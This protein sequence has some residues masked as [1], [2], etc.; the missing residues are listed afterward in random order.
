M[1]QPTFASLKHAAIAA[2]GSPAQRGSILVIS[3]LILLV[4]TIIGVTALND[5]VLEEK[6]S[7][8]FQTGFTAF[9]AT[10][11]AINLTFIQVS[12][13]D[14]LFI[15]AF[16]AA[17]NDTPLPTVAVDMNKSSNGENTSADG[18][19]SMNTVIRFVSKSDDSKTGEGNSI[20]I[21]DA[22]PGELYEIVAT[23]NVAN[24]NIARTHIQGVHRRL[25]KDGAVWD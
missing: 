5:S 20:N 16:D 3:L 10:E 14:D 21:N 23:G 24:T 15:S 7:A 12:Q 4:L 6:M 8:N 22:F 2:P 25:P 1:R 11:S 9:Q 19:V 13:Q 18:H 17:K